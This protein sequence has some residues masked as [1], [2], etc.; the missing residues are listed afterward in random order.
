MERFELISS[1]NKAGATSAVFKARDRRTGDLAAVKILRGATAIERDRFANEARVLA[2]L[3]HPA[4]VPYVDHGTTAAGEPFL[5]MAWIDG[6][7]V[8]DALAAGALSAADT[9]AVV[10]RVAAAL[11]AAH[12]RGVIHRD[13]KPSNVVTP[14]GRCGDAVLIDFGIAREADATSG[15]TRT[16]VAVGTPGYMSPEQARAHKQ[17]EAPSDVFGLGC[18]A[19]ECLAGRAPFGAEHVMA[20]RLRVLLGKPEPLAAL[21]PAAP[22][23]LVALIEQMLR[24]RADE[25]PADGAAVVAALVA[26][27]G[28]GES[29]R[30]GDAGRDGEAGRDGDAGRDASAAYVVLAGPD[31]D[32]DGAAPGLDLAERLGD[33]L[34]A[35]GASA[36]TMA[37]GALAVVVGDADQAARRAATIALAIR[38]RMRELPMMIARLPELLGTSASAAALDRIV[39]GLGASSIRAALA[40]EAPICVDADVAAALAPAFVVEMVDRVRVLRG[41]GGAT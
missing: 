37:D 13:V 14:G 22:P 19:Y 17:L 2:A 4:I 25:R 5:A 36:I 23:P 35:G 39:G 24:K 28:D 11:G 18:L 33:V 8:R 6:P 7:T 27:A 41:P 31:T 12:A 34:T 21:A 15:L 9:I 16:G 38:A 1:V 32:A 40:D 29:G 26:L 10:R 3:S 20:V 30:D